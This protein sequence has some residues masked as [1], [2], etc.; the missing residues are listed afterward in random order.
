MFI[1]P[2]ISFAQQLSREELDS[3]YQ[4]FVQ[5]RAPH[6]LE[7]PELLEELSLSDKKCGFGIENR[8]KI[9]FEN[10]SAEQQAVLK[11]LLLRPET[12]TSVVSPSGFF[13]IHY[14]TTNI[15]SS[16]PAYISG[17]S[18]EANVQEVVKAIDSTY[19]FEIDYLGYPQPPPDGNEGGDNL[20]DVYIINQPS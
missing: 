5:V 20:Y 4:K 2:S 16:I 14:D 6:L 15:R 13:R 8:V 18:I 12:E 17:A 19:S 7:Q 9:N 10:F 11:P 3:L 1:V